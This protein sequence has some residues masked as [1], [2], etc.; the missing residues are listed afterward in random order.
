MKISLNISLLSSFYS[1]EIPPRDI[2][3]IQ[4]SSQVDYKQI[5]GISLR[6]FQDLQKFVKKGNP[7]SLLKIRKLWFFSPA[8]LYEMCDTSSEFCSHFHANLHKNTSLNANL[9]INCVS[10][11]FHIGMK[12]SS[13]GRNVLFL[14]H[15]HPHTYV[16]THAHIGQID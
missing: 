12:V 7:F 2:Q 8:S 9:V 3:T 15:T 13:V 6:V 11:F 16:F 14:Q 10:S 5:F 4:R 1:E